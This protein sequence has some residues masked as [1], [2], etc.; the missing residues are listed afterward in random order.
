MQWDSDDPRLLSI[1]SHLH[2]L[3]ARAAEERW[4]RQLRPARSKREVRRLRRQLGMLLITAGM[5]LIDE[6]TPH[7]VC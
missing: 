2:E 3:R 5:A 4:A 7:C 1:E 6:P